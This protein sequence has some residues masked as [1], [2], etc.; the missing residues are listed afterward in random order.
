MRRVSAEDGMLL[1]ELSMTK[2]INLT[3]KKTIFLHYFLAEVCYNL[4]SVCFSFQHCMSWLFLSQLPCKA[5][6]SLVPSATVD[7][8]F[9]PLG[10]MTFLIC[11]WRLPVGIHTSRTTKRRHE[12]CNTA[13]KARSYRI[14]RQ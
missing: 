3:L 9:V 4:E 12:C 1:G 13:K 14:W 2:D 7:V 10:L 8:T 5:F 11:S 6:A